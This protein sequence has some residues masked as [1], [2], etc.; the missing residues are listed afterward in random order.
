VTYEDWILAVAAEAPK[1]SG[2]ALKLLLHLAAVSI[3]TGTTQVRLSD[4]DLEK[5]LGICRPALTEAKGSLADI[6]GIES[7]SGVPSVFNLPAN[8]FPGQRTLFVQP[9]ANFPS[10]Q[11]LEKLASTGQENWPPVA[12]KTGHS[13]QENWP[14]GQENWPQVA[15]KT[16]QVANKTGHSGQEN[17]PPDTKNQRLVAVPS[18]SNRVESKVVDVSTVE[19]L[20]RVLDSVE[21]PPHRRVEAENL[22]VHLQT[23]L[24][25]RGKGFASIKP[26][27]DELAAK[28]LAIG[29]TEE[30]LGALASLAANSSVEP[31]GYFWF[32]VTFLDQVSGIP[33]KSTMARLAARK[34]RKQAGRENTLPFPAEITQQ[35]VANAKTLR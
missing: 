10:H 3:Q 16:G 23:F 4:R 9:V 33:A 30:L 25:Q 12:N 5:Q 31:R 24:K 34:Q 8:W 20:D 19:I 35:L 26:P 7:R 14:G 2:S 17:W 18:S 22:K 28:C 27:K 21:I 6:I 32:V 1:R 11:R 29:G 15:N 13:G